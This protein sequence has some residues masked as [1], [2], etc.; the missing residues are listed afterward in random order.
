MVDL[1]RPRRGSPARYRQI[2]CILTRHGLGFLVDRLGLPRPDRP[3]R[4]TPS[5]ES[6]HLPPTLAARVRLALED[7]GATFIKLG[8]ILSTRGD[9]IPPELAAELGRLQD[10]VPPEPLEV[11]EEVIAEE[12]GRPASAVFASLEAEPLGSASI[13]QVHAATLLTGEQVVVKVQ[14]PRV[15][16]QVEE[17][18]AILSQLARVAQRR[19]SWGRVHHLPA[20]VDEFA[21]TLRA[22]LDYVR[23]ARNAERIARNFSGV[24]DLRVPAIYWAYTTQR[25]LTMERIDGIRIADRAAMQAAG[26]DLRAVAVRTLHMSLKMVLEDGFYHADPHPGNFLVGPDGSV[27][28]LDFGMIGVLDRP[29]RENLLYL[30][31]ALVEG[32]ADR[33]VDRMLALGIVGT[34]FQIEQMKHDI[35]HLILPGAGLPEEEPDVHRFLDGLLTMAYRR[36]LIVP[37]SLLLVCKTIMMHQALARRCDPEC[38]LAEVLGSYARRLAV[39]SYLP[40]RQIG[41]V[42]TALSDLGDLALTLPR[43]IHRLLLETEQGH[44]TVNIRIREIEHV[45]EVLNRLVNRLVLAIVAAGL[46]VATALLLQAYRFRGVE[47]I[48]GALLM[49]GFVAAVG[50]ALWVI[51]MVVRRR[52]H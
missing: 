31:L 22:E 42:L 1:G 15:A 8:Q 6:R 48:A 2:A 43:H 23:E 36:Q 39:E 5:Q 35:R 7:L 41:R 14:R 10:A 46:T 51:L 26:I 27:G 38:S 21:A 28:L 17:D 20:V 18:L 52:H 16:E 25:V 12:L 24:P 13:G 40:H 45:L 32:D 49:A 3:D 33:L 11:V 4:G 34:T 19:T 37:S 47:W 9:L 44:L 29:T 50:L 30:L